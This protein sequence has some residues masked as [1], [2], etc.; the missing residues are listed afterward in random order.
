MSEIKI[1]CGSVKAKDTQYGEL[2]DVTL[3]LDTVLQ[4]VQQGH[5]FTTDQGRQK[6]RLTIGR[7]QQIGTYGETH[8]IT[9]NT[10]KP[11]TQNNQQ[12]WGNQG[13]NQQGNQNWGNQQNQQS[14]SQQPPQQQGFQNQ[15]P[16]QGYYGNQ[17]GY[18]G[19]VQSGGY[20]QAPQN[21]PVNNHQ[22]QP[23]QHQAAPQN[24][25]T[26]GQ[27]QQSIPFEQYSGNP[28]QPFKAPP[29]GNQ[30]YKPTAMNGGGI[31]GVDDGDIPF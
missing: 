31:A 10:F 25:P 8:T 14:W 19:N 23:P 21:P 28:S 16:Q 17:G 5:G 30:Q 1:Y 4:A 29:Q 15:P 27:Q 24:Q 11:N 26:Q 2:L 18:G 13:N 7:R 3:D 20:H 6:I 12:N 9:V 22:Y